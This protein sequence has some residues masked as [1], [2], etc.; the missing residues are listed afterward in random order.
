MATPP[1]SG[2]LPGSGRDAHGCIP[3]AGYSWCE[4]LA[5]CVRPW[6]THCPRHHGRVAHVRRAGSG[7]PL[8]YD[9]TDYEGA[10]L[11]FTIPVRDRWANYPYF[12]RR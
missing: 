12:S 2:L 7:V 5:Q 3:S 1:G 4:A 11:P 6:E 9:G 8:Y 10:A